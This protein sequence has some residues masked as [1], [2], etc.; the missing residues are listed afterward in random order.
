MKSI[1]PSCRRATAHL[2]RPRSTHHLLARLL[3]GACFL[4]P[5]LAPAQAPLA[6]K[7]ATELTRSIADFGPIK[8]PKDALATYEKAVAELG[9]TGGILVIPAE[10][11]TV[12]KIENTSQT[13]ARIPPLPQ[14]T[15]RWETTPGIVV[16]NA[17]P[18]HLTVR[19]PQV[20]GLHIARTLRMNPGESL[21]HWGTHPMIMLENNLVYGSI[22]YLDWI[23]EPVTAG[24]DRRFYLAT[25]RGIRPGEF[26][27][28]HGG[29]GYGGGVTR[30]Y[31][32]SVG[33]DTAKK[34][35]YF[36]ADT[37]I[38][39]K[40]GAIVHNKSNTGVLHMTQDS[41]NDNQTYDVKLI[42][43]QYAHGDTYGFYMDF[44]YMSDVHSAAGDENGNCYAAFIRSLSK[45]NF[46]GRVAEMDWTKQQLTFTPTSQNINTLGDSRPLIN[47]NP[48]KLIKQG[49]VWIVPA[50]SYMATTDTGKYPFEKKTYP[51]LIR[52]DPVTKV[53][54]IKMG[55]LIRGDKDCPWTPEIVGRF[56]AVTEPGELIP[57]GTLRRW[58]EIT[59]FKQNADGT[60]DI[61][62]R[63]F[64]WGAKSAGS[65][66]LYNKD[67]YSYD[68]HLRPLSYEIAPGT[69]VNDVS[70]AIPGGDRGGQRMLG[71]APHTDQGAAKDFAA[72]DDIEQA[73]GPDPFKPQAFRIWMWE[74]VP[75]AWPS[76]VM[77]VANQGEAS[78]HAFLSLRG[79]PAK[80][81]DLEKRAEKKPAWDN[82]IVVGSSVTVGLNFEADVANA[83]ILFQQPN[84]EQPIKWH[85]DQVEGKA[86]KEATLTVSKATGELTFQGGGVRAG[87]PVSGVAGLS[88][89]AKPAKNLRGKN[90]VVAV[91][92]AKL[93][94][95]FPT[96]EADAD[97]AVFIEQS[98]LGQRA[99]SE[100]TAEGFTVNFD[101]PA[102]AEA[103]LDW[104]LV[105]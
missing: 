46:R 67:N 105:R 8:A 70:Y 19:V 71:L 61:E 14:P 16:V 82:V 50:E 60:K 44:D 34:M 43:R 7:P 98:W 85:Y 79:G 76:A 21:P 81:E 38:D 86:P 65:P 87:G 51:T 42:R 94:V 90:L 73:I 75:G 13:I 29:P 30:G 93:R 31:V 84:H 49:K 22:S 96:P 5:A 2:F 36:V 64:W 37:E 77:D 63:R 52:P 80:I 39:H 100:K 3:L 1:S 102:P 74:D 40:V 56:F 10:L 20:E 88:G 26:L 62:I 92:A 4:L 72:G 45:G 78:R 99:I 25:V 91:N 32:K 35:H 15:K 6:P 89:D 24:K 23:Q 27:N 69:Y 41:H 55:G 58:Y 97:Y 28:L 57:K 12:L 48:A 95:T 33:Y 9:K 68:G 17:D 104:M 11:S 101:K 53:S 59:A 103:K 83:A 18:K 47:L 54:G 66:T